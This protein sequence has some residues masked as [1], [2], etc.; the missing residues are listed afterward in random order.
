MKP[1]ALGGVGNIGFSLA[2][3]I[4][5]DSSEKNWSANIFHPVNKGET[6]QVTIIY[7]GNLNPRLSPTD[8]HAD[9]TTLYWDQQT[10]ATGYAIVIWVKHEDLWYKAFQKLTTEQS[11]T[12]TK[13]KWAFSP[14]IGDHIRF[15][16]YVLNDDPVLDTEAKTGAS[17]MESLSFTY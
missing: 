8:I 3:S 12:Y 7:P 16:I 6:N 11:T 5:T 14:S 13:S 1:A 9:T 4:L 10:G 17:F 2:G 15:E